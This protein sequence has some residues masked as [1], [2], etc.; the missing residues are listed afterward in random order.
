ME[1]S[2][3]VSN[4]SKKYGNKEILRDISFEA[5]KGRITAFLGPNGAGKSTTL[6]ILLGLD[7]ADSGTALIEG[8]KYSKW[9][10]PLTKIGASFDGVGSPG[11]RTVYQHLRIISVS[12]GIPKKRIFEVME[13]TGISHKASSQV[14]SLSLGEGQRLGIAAA[15]IGDPQFLIFDEPTNGL[16][17]SGIR[18]FREFVKQQAM[19]GKTVLLS[20]HML[21]EVEA[22]T[23]DV[24][25]INHGQVVTKG[26]LDTVMKDLSSLEDL[27]FTLTDE[28]KT[29]EEF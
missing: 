14:G 6:R 27:F 18:W 20:S 1:Q 28:V 24:V 13:I 5:K 22:V 21:S 19:G 10:K 17:P 7:R 8:K 26:S 23:N 12:N 29:N 15:L 16:D 11:N 3:I 4:I 2:I 25:I 9:Q